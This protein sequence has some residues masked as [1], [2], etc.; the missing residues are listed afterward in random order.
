MFPLLRP[1]TSF[2]FATVVALTLAVGTTGSA[3]AAKW[4]AKQPA[5][6]TKSQAGA[7]GDATPSELP[8]SALVSHGPGGEAIGKDCFVVK[9]R[10]LVP[11]AGYM[12]RR[13]TFCN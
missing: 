3:E 10:A 6:V 12:I 1:A 9:K 7:S 2:G 13:S 8:T 5:K 4:K 11:G